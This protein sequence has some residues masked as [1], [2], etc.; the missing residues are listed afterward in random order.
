MAKVIFAAEMR[1]LTGGIEQAQV[2]AT[3]YRRALRELKQQ[4]PQLSENIFE[5]FALAIDGVMI[6]TPLMETFDANSEVVF[7]P[8]IPSG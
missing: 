2:E 8:K 5:K 4:F 1:Q 3:T 6:Q 7:V